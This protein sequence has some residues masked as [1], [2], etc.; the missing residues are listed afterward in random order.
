M[1]ANSHK[2]PVMQFWLPPQAFLLENLTDQIAGWVT[3]L[4]LARRVCS[5]SY[6]ITILFNTLLSPTPKFFPS[7]RLDS[8]SPTA[9]QTFGNLCLSPY[10]LFSWPLPL[11]FKWSFFLHSGA[12]GKMAVCTCLPL[13]HNTHSIAAFKMGFMHSSTADPEP[14]IRCLLCL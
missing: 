3:A 5:F 12:L 2:L 1:R 9:I 10:V 11:I 13:P 4:Q 14:P 7:S 6:S 8:P